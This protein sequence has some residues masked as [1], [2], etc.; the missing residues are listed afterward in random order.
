MDSRN[1]RQY[2]SD[3]DYAYN[4]KTCKVYKPKGDDLKDGFEWISRTAPSS[5]SACC[6]DV[7]DYIQ[8]RMPE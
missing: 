6:E 2:A 7:K 4:S 1:W 5:R 3:H 8:A